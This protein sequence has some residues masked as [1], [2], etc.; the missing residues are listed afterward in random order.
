MKKYLLMLST[1][2]FTTT[3]MAIEV[4]RVQ[5]G[6]KIDTQVGSISNRGRFQNKNSLPGGAELVSTAIVND[7]RIF[8]GME[9]KGNNGLKYGARIELFADVSPS[10]SNNPNH[11]DK[12]YAYA[13]SMFG[14]LEGGAVRGASNQMAINAAT[15]A[16]ATGGVDGAANNWLPLDKPSSLP[17]SSNFYSRYQTTP[18]L[19]TFID[20]VSAAGKINYFTPKFA[21]F[22]IGVGYIP[23]IQLR[24][25]VSQTHTITHEVGKGYKNIYDASIK[26]EGK[27]SE[28]SYAASFGAEFGD[29]KT[30][31]R[32]DE[33]NDL[34]AWVAGAKVMYKGLS[35]A[36]SY[37]SWGKS[38][39]PKL[40]HD[41]MKYGTEHFTL[42]TAY[43][44]GDA[45]ASVT[46]LESRRGNSYGD[47]LPIAPDMQDITKNKFKL[48]SF[49][50]D[51]K[52]A[53]GIKPYVEVSL[54]Q[55][56]RKLEPYNDKGNLVLVGSKLTF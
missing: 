49:G 5:L 2:T 15:I 46:Y 11:G 35:L 31:T 32:G 19:P 36:G 53:Q 37:G 6:G 12:V 55:Y 47:L 28:V 39:T 22:Q 9:G 18:G 16:S 45:S 42:G 29:A 13:E 27:L 38:A 40:K 10:P 51:Y 4:P 20:H 14:R 30:T 44:F 7:T 33:K 41:G 23:D 43:A 17:S 1:L 26:Y 56:K 21:G 8:F 52:L 25:T 54:F 24:G 3:A 50:V 48:L 34:K